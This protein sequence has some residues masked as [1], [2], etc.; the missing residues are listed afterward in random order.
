RRLVHD[1]R[2]GLVRRDHRQRGGGDEGALTP[3]RP[4]LEHDDESGSRGQT[5]HPPGRDPDV[6]PP[7]VTAQA[8]A[9]GRG[10]LAAP[11]GT[12]AARAMTFETRMRMTSSRPER[13]STVAPESA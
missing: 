10:R 11:A 6:P 8:T 2:R 9:P 1:L 12:S 4:P 5:Q 3:L 7:Q 13:R